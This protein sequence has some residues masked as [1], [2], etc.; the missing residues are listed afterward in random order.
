MDKK[1]RCCAANLA[2]GPKAPK[3]NPFNSCLHFKRRAND[4]NAEKIIFS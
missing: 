3:K 1:T 2:I 4:G